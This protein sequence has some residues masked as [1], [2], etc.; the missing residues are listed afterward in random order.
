[1][2]TRCFQAAVTLALVVGVACGDSQTTSIV[3]ATTTSTQDSGLLDVLLPRFEQ[4]HGIEVKVIAVGTG[5]ALRMAASGDADVVLVHAPVAERRYVDSG[6]LSGGRLVMHNE[7]VIVGPDADPAGV[8]GRSSANEAMQAIAARGVF[9]SRG[10]ESGTHT[11]ELAL[12][13]AAGV[14]PGVL[15]RRLETGQGMGATLNVA[16]EKAAYTLTD[17]ATYLA[18]RQRLRLVVVFEGDATLVNP[19]HVYAVNDR[20]HP[21]VNAA[22]ARVLVEFLV[23]PPT[24]QAIADFGRAEFGQSLFIPDAVAPSQRNSPRD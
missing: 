2:V 10:D 15:A 5:A 4:E 19:Y 11:E 1:M 3:L 21:K 7:F 23:S 12:W 24:Q 14:D 17:R 16:S 6:D 22:G 20:K 18:L 8:R 9:V 13:A